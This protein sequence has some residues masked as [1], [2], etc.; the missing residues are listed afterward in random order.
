M[1]V[2]KQ[3]FAGIYPVRYT[4]WEKGLY[5]LSVISGTTLVSGSSYTVEVAN[6]TPQASSSSAFGNGLEA[7]VAGESS[8]FEVRVKD[9]R[10]SEIQSIKTS[11]I[12]IDFID[13][14]QQIQVLSNLGETFRIEFRGQ[15]SG[16]IEVGLSTLA[17]IAEALE[18]LHSIGQ[19]NVSSNGSSVIQSGD[20]IDVEFLTEHGSLDLMKSNGPE[21]ITTVIEGEAPFRA[22]R[23]AF[24]CDADGGYVILS[25]KDRTATIEFNDDIESVISKLSLLFGN[26]VS[27]VDLDSSVTTICNSIGKVLFVDFQLE[28]GDVVPVNVSFDALENGSISIFGDGEGH[29]GAVNGV[30]AIMG[31]FSLTHDGETTTPISVDATDQELKA[32]LENLPSVGSVSVTKDM[33]GIRRGKD[34]QNIVPGTSS[35]FSIWSIK[36]ADDSEDGCHTGSWDK[37]PANIGDV[38]PLVIDAS[39]LAYEIGATQQQSAPSIENFEVKKGSAGNLLDDVDGQSEIHFSLSHNLMQG[40]GIELQEVHTIACAY[41]TEALDASGSFGLEILNKRI[42]VDA[43]ASMSELKAMLRGALGLTHPVYS[44]GSTHGT[45]CHF[46][47]SNPVT[48]VTKLTFAKENGPI[49]HFYVDSEQNVAVT[50]NNL[51]DAVDKIEYLGGGRHIV[52]YTPTISGHYSAS[53]QLNNEDLWTDLSAGVVINPAE[54]SAHHCTHDSILVAV[55]GN[56]HSFAVVARDRFGNRLSSPEP[57][58]TSLVISLTGDSDTCADTQRHDNPNTTIEELNI[59]SPDGHYKMAYTP[60]LAGLYR[61]SIMVRSRGGLLATYFKNQDFS[62]PVYGNTNHN[63]PPY[64]ETPWCAG[65]MPVC[66]STHLDND[67]SFDWGFESPLAWDPSFPMDSFSITWDGEIRVDVAEEYTFTVHLNGGVR[68][69]IGEQV[70]IDKLLDAS[71]ES[72]SSFPVM[73]MDDI[74]YRIKVEYVHSIDEARIQLFWESSSMPRQIVPSSVFHYTRHISGSPPSPFSVHSAPGDIDVS[75]IAQGE[76][77]TGC[78]SL[79]ECSFVIQTKD[80]NQNNRY[81]DG[82]DPGFEITISGNGGWAGEG[83]I[84]SVVSSSPVVISD[85]TVTS[86]DWQYIGEVDV[87]HRSDHI[88][89]KTSFVG[90]L[91]RGDQISV[92]GTMYTVSSTGTFDST[93][94]PLLSTYLGPAKRGVSV[95]KASSSCMSGTHTVKYTPTVRG[96]YLMDVKLPMVTEIQRV[97]TSPR[98]HPSLSGAFTLTYHGQL[99]ADPLVSG[100]IDFNA[101]SEEFQ[102]ALESI[103]TI[104][105]VAVT[106]HDCNNPAISCS[107]D[108]TFLSV[109]G[110]VNMLVPNKLQLGGD[111]AEVFVEELVKG[112]RPKSITGFP[113]TIDVSPGQ[114]SP[115]RTT[116][117]GRGIVSA[118][119]GDKSTFVILP[120][121]SSG[122]DRLAGQSADLFAVYIYPEEGN[123]DGSFPIIEGGIHR[124]IDGFYTVDYVPKTSGFHTVAVVQA[125]STEEQIISTGYNTKARGGTFTINL[126]QLSTPPISWDADEVTLRN[127]LDSSM[128]NIST[129]GVEK[130]THGLFNYKYI[131][132][133]ES[134][135]GDVP[136]FVVGTSDL[137]GNANDWDVVSASDGKFSH[138]KVD[139]PVHEIQSIKLVILD[140]ASLVGATFSLAFMGQSTDPIPWDANEHEVLQKLE[141]LS[142]VGDILV[143][144]DIDEATNDRSWHVTFNPYEGKSANS[145]FNFGNLPPFKV[146]NSGG[147]I[148]VLVDTIE[149]GISPFQVFVSPAESSSGNMT[150]HD[151]PGVRHFEGLSTAVYMSDSHFFIQSRDEFSN[152]IQEGPLREVQIIETTSSSQIGGYFEVSMFEATIRVHASAF[153]SELE[154]SLQ[155]IPGVG[156]LEVSSKSAKDLVIGKTVAVT[157]GLDTIIPSEELDEFIVGDWIRIGDQDEGPL[158]SITE[159]ADVTPFTVTLSSPYLGEPSSS[160]NIYQHGSSQNRKGYQYIVSFDAVLGD[161][162]RLDVD[163]TLLKGADA[164]IEVTSCNWNVHQSI[165]THAKSPTPIEGYFYLTYGTEQTRLLSVGTPEDELED[166][167]LSDISSIHSLS[168]TH[169]QDH[170]LGATSWAIHLMSFDGDAQLFFAEGHLLSGGT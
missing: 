36:F 16:N 147:S 41:S 160:S 161:L 10:Q 7:G 151:H 97:T 69:S 32:A 110:D 57:N 159:I 75:S 106:L 15:S 34:G 105:S 37:C 76:G 84:N 121:D 129:F 170:G 98:S 66:D 94:V 63:F 12:V 74:F 133:F 44:A 96:S 103:E 166:A 127:A 72:V 139:E 131:I 70:V 45:V 51:V 20:M 55:A 43:Q 132:S 154:K 46:D 79:E 33:F 168:V 93:S 117:Y 167:I 38:A 83:R 39:M 107:W 136:N 62:Q 104:G 146:I 113:R 52:T 54:A 148:S 49:P 19:V 77:L 169:E 9:R 140:P 91:L 155:S 29:Q 90:T 78:V 100:S 28:L 108:V 21:I 58:E 145:L 23:H 85:A 2:L 144:L 31:H 73:L 125:V 30:S 88:A 5:E 26:P 143:S 122:N 92:D 86:N 149:N 137:I 119:A 112:R 27:I 24:Y 40:V 42:L 164:Q 116:A 95:Y 128:E 124:D 18:A 126:G 65:D 157:K 67:I 120:K 150:A 163:G 60:S 71:A 138:I 109:G 156:S 80:L 118:T 165:R 111:I 61:T 142:T 162:P 152:E 50:T 89:S 14:V 134:L 102:I 22:E 56:E 13:E 4:L 115:S 3:P 82:S 153:T 59:G 135:L 35:L 68:F 123:E 6:G 17:D 158:F 99:G 101:N 25:F 48:A 1:S 8:S 47:P 141:M 130:K 81:N 11:A 53:V 64:H 114:T 87:T